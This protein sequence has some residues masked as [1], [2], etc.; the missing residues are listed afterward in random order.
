MEANVKTN[1][2]LSKIL[3]VFSDSSNTP[4]P[5]PNAKE[6]CLIS[7]YGERI[8]IDD[9]KRLSKFYSSVDNTIDYKCFLGEFH[10]TREIPED[11]IKFKK[12]II[13]SYQSKGFTCIILNDILKS[14]SDSVLF[15]DWKAKY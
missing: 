6:A 4:S 12:E 8:L 3:K 2:F 13:K 15:I 11:L 9:A 10:C 7:M 5:K 14:V 1:S